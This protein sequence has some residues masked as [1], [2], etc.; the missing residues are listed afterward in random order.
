MK[1]ERK[2]VSAVALACAALL[3]IGSAMGQAAP[4]AP[5]TP[6]NAYHAS[7]DA[8][9]EARA[10][11]RDVDRAVAVIQRMRAD[12]NANRL[13]QNAKGVFVAPE[14][15]AGAVGI[16]GGGGVGLLLVKHDGAWTDPAFYNFGGVSAGAQVGG[17]GG[18]FVLVLNNDKAV[19]SFT[20]N[21][22]W[23]LDANA[24]LT[25][26]KWS[27]EHAVSTGQGD[28]TL[29]S[30]A[31]GLFAGVAVGVTDI[32]FDRDQTSAYYGRNVAVSDVVNGKVSK[33]QTAELKHAL[34]A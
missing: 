27:E 8:K 1:I 2:V 29:W 4:G 5:G 25:I 20:R 32:K 30:D 26:M 9:D 21:S 22:D 31:K 33:P 16:G 13:L 10:A 15:G 28:I 14:F 19:Q 17:E 12:P 23:S 6:S 34:A 3:S 7:A 18:S 24:G 11:A